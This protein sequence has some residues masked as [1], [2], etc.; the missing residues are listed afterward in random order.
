MLLLDETPDPAPHVV[1]V[2]VGEDQ[3]QTTLLL[4]QKARQ[5]GLHV[6]LDYQ[7]NMGKR[8]KKAA[9]MNAPTVWLVGGD[10]AKTQSVT[11]KNMATGDQ[12][13]LSTDQAIARAVKE[14]E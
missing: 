8:M 7:G 14:I 3:E 11:W 4:A 1:I 6:W 5:A 12:E 9:K 10:E 13:L 2:P